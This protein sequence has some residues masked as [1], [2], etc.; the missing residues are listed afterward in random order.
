MSETGPWEQWVSP[1]GQR[2]AWVNTESGAVWYA[3][4][5]TPAAAADLAVVLPRWTRRC[6]A[7]DEDDRQR[8][9]G[10]LRL[11]EASHV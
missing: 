5:L 10:H 8:V 6:P 2:M 3:Y 7:P 1:C 4:R 9:G 11:M